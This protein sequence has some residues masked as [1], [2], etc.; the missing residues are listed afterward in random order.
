M[1]TPPRLFL[2]HAVTAPQLLSAGVHAAACQ[3]DLSSLYAFMQHIRRCFPL[4]NVPHHGLDR[5]IQKWM[6][7]LI[8]CN[9][10]I[11]NTTLETSDKSVRYSVKT[12]RK[13]MGEDT[14]K[15][16]KATVQDQ[17]GDDQTIGTIEWSLGRPGKITMGQVSTDDLTF[18]R[19]KQRLLSRKSDP[20]VIVSADYLNS[21]EHSP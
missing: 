1:I 15:I 14:T 21:Q 13:I 5:G 17:D 7:E 9:D 8:I 10:D 2:V 20:F 3:N 12:T 18:L 19:G 4:S 16:T 6:M 11:L